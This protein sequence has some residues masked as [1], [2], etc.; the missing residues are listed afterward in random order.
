[1]TIEEDLALGNHHQIR[2]D[3]FVI[4]LRSVR[5]PANMRLVKDGNEI[6]AQLKPPQQQQQQAKQQ[7]PLQLKAAQRKPEPIR[8]I[9]NVVLPAAGTRSLRSI[10]GRAANSKRKLPRSSCSTA[11]KPKPK[12]TTTSSYAN[13]LSPVRISGRLRRAPRAKVNLSNKKLI[14]SESDSSDDPDDDDNDNDD[15][16]WLDS[17]EPLMQIKRR[18][19][20]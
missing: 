20:H 14:E 15:D 5:V 2:P 16:D 17:K 18:V 3:E 1:M 4:E 9:K 12:R 6:Q 7:Q 8:R 19:I 11:D 10:K 13:D